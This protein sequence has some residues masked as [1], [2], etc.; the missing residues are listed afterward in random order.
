MEGRKPT[1][2]QS[3]SVRLVGA[4]GVTYR[5][6]TYTRPEAENIWL[7]WIEFRSEDGSAPTLR[8]GTETSQPSLAA[9]AYWASGLEPVFF[10]GALVR[11]RGRQ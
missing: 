3:H 7:A 6:F 11:A 5:P 9:I 2:V 10:E 8:T 1:L 4:D